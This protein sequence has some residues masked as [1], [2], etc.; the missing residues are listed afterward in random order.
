MTPPSSAVKLTCPHPYSKTGKFPSTNGFR[1]ACL[2]SHR[3]CGW[4]VSSATATCSTSAAVHILEISGH[5]EGSIAIHLPSHGVLFTGDTIANVGTVMLGAFNQNRA[6]T[7]ASFRRLA[8]L[9][10]E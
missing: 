7:V 4:T 8:E 6:R 1:P 9:D 5:T 2:L 3:R 10:V